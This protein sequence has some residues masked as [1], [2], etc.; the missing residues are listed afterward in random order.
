L[1]RRWKRRAGIVLA[2]A[3]AAV[4]VFSQ[5][6][7]AST[8]V[9]WLWTGDAGGAVFFDADLNGEP[10]IEK[11]TVCDEWADGRG[12]VAYLIHGSTLVELKDP[13]YDLKCVSLAKNMFVEETKVTVEVC[14][15]ADGN[16]FINCEAEYAY[17]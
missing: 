16:Y 6:A 3:A 4:L 17:A 1:G 5:Q 8:N 15:Y 12:V 2:T 9:G 7:Q 13:S 10:G 14:E 11:V